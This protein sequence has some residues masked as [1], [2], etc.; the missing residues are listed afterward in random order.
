MILSKTTEQSLEAI[1]INL[2][3]IGLLVRLF[4]EIRPFQIVAELHQRLCG[5][6]ASE[7]THGAMADR[8]GAK[9]KIKEKE[10]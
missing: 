9:H 3:G 7:E 1:C 6:F 2:R 5:C 4:A 10:K 8:H